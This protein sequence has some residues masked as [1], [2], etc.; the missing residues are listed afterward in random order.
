M[1]NYSGYESLDESLVSLPKNGVYNPLEF[2]SNLK[3]G[4]NGFFVGVVQQFLKDIELYNKSIS[5]VFDSY[6]QEVLDEFK[7]NF[8][9]IKDDKLPYR[10]K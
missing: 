7:L 1:I 10:F 9:K 2:I 5:F 3:L 4:D 8:A 6:A